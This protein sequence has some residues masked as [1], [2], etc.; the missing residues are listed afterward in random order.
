MGGDAHTLATGPTGTGSKVLTLGMCG[1][2]PAGPQRAVVTMGPVACGGVWAMH[3]FNLFFNHIIFIFFALLIIILIVVLYW[4][5][6]LLYQKTSNLL[7]V[8][9]WNS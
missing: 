4:D 7:L 6:V 8:G 3:P 9:I 1:D 5:V 2:A